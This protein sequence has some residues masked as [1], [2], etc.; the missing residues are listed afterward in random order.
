MKWLTSSSISRYFR[1]QPV[2]EGA[3]HLGL[4]E[5]PLVTA[6]R[7]ARPLGGRAGLALS[8]SHFSRNSC[9]ACVQHILQYGTGKWTARGGERREVELVGGGWFGGAAA[10]LGGGAEISRHF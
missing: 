7:R 4:A 1:G 8:C 5:V 9:I 2:L 3:E 6:R 10:H